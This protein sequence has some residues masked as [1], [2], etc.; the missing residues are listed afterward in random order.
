MQRVDEHVVGA[1]LDGR[2]DAEVGQVGQV[3]GAPR[4]GRPD[5]VELGGEPPEAALPQPRGHAHPVR[6][7]DQAHPGLPVAAAGV[8]PVVPQGQVAGD[9]ERRLA[10]QLAVHR[11]GRV[12]VVVLVDAAPVL[13]GLQL[14]PHVDGPPLG[15]VH[16]ERRPPPLARHQHRRQHPPPGLVGLRADSGAGRVLGARVDAE[17]CEHRDHVSVATSTCWPCQSQ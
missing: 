10:D 11:A 17:R 9:R 5:A 13:A 2:P 1:V 14:H 7:D 15:H 6:R 12:P 4:A 3:A 8:H 16:V